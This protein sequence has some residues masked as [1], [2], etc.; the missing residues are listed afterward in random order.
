MHV[1]I[2]SNWQQIRKEVPKRWS[3]IRNRDLEQLDGSFDQLVSL[4]QEKYGYAQD[5]AEEE[6]EAFLQEVGGRQNGEMVS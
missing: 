2:Q 5:H 1:D 3:K 6:V 4:V